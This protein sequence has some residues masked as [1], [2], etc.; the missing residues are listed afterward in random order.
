MESNETNTPFEQPQ[1]LGFNEEGDEIMVGTGPADTLTKVKNSVD[2][3]HKVII[4][5]K[6]R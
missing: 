5:N 6:I 4:S 2:N 3:F 1:K